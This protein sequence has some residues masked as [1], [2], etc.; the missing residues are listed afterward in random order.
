MVSDSRFEDSIK[1][2]KGLAL[3]LGI[4][5]AVFTLTF[6]ALMHVNSNLPAN[7]DNNLAFLVPVYFIGRTIWSF[8]VWCWLIAILGYGKKY[9]NK[10]NSFIEHF[11]EIALPFYILHQ[12]VII[13]IGLYVIQWNITILLK[14]ITITTAY[15]FISFFLCKLIKTNNITRYIFGMKVKNKKI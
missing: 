1:R 6:D 11:S 4:F 15:L 9:L 7:I 3:I 10:K 8:C 14:Y 13:I 2:N 5:I 12:T